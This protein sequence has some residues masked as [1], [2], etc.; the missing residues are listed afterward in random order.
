MIQFIL[1]REYP[2]NMPYL[3]S[4]RFNSETLKQNQNWRDANEYGGCV[5]GS[6]KRIKEDVPIGANL[7]VL[8]MQND[9]NK[10]VGI[11]MIRNILALDRKYKIYDWGNYNRYIYKGEFRIDRNNCNE[12][13][14]KVMAILDHLVF[15]GSRHLKRGSGITCLPAWIAHNRHM[16]FTEKINDMFKERY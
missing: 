1:S 4:I 12:E 15:K 3:A 5:Y 8:E 16:D 11:G 6:P 14:E 7:I 2:L 10:I 9:I 13:E